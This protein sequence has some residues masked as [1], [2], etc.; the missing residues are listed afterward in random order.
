MSHRPPFSTEGTTT[1]KQTEN[2]SVHYS[3]VF[4]TVPL[5]I[6]HGYLMKQSTEPVSRLLYKTVVLFY[7][8]FNG[9]ANE[10][11]ITCQRM[12]KATSLC[13]NTYQDIQERE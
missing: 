6:K 7:Y 1:A 11:G 8:Q 9:S 10:K 13:V 12:S 4:E 5:W 2:S 3:K